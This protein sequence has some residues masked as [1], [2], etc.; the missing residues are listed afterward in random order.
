MT[1]AL[2]EPPTRRHENLSRETEAAWRSYAGTLLWIHTTY[3]HIRPGESDLEALFAG[4]AEAIPSHAGPVVL[5]HAI[6]CP[7]N[8]VSVTVGDGH[9]SARDEAAA[10]VRVISSMNAWWTA[11][12]E[13]DRLLFSF[14][15]EFNI[16]GRR[17]VAQQLEEQSRR[18]ESLDEHVRLFRALLETDLLNSSGRERRLWDATAPVWWFGENL[19]AVEN[20]VGA[21]RDLQATLVRELESR[22][23]NRLDAMV[24]FFTV[25]AVLGGVASVALWVAPDASSGARV[26]LTAVGVVLS[27][28][29]LAAAFW[30]RPFTRQRAL[31]V[32]EHDVADLGPQPAPAPAT[33]GSGG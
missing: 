18:I 17:V 5:P 25:F 24:A 26:A 32:A 30:N 16:A 6:V 9:A 1:S 19:T 29:V 11:I 23:S 14:L 21:L 8:L 33:G 28:L 12:W 15:N 20:K 2:F 3:T 13:L 22:R 7:G 10:L 31:R 27:L 4:L